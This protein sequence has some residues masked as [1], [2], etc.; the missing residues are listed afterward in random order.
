MNLHLNANLLRSGWALQTS[1]FAVRAGVSEKETVMNGKAPESRRC[2]GSESGF[3]LL[4]LMVSIAI[5]L[6]ITGATFSVMSSYQKSYGTTQLKADMYM[7]LRGVSE[8]MA[9]EIGQ[10]GLKITPT[11]PQAQFTG[12][13]VG[14]GFGTAP[15]TTSIG[16]AVGNQVMIDQGQPAQETVT[17][18]AVTTGVPGT[19]SATFGQNHTSGATVSIV[20]Q[21]VYA[22]GVLPFS[23]VASPVSTAGSTPSTLELFGD[24]NSNG[25][26]Q[27]VYYSCNPSAQQ[28]PVAGTLVR[29]ITRLPTPGGA[30]APQTLLNTLVVNPN[31]PVTGQP[32]PCFRLGTQT[33]AGTTFVSNVGVTLSVRTQEVDKVTGQYLVMTKSFMNL[34]PRNTLG[35]L[36]LSQ[37]QL[38]NYLLPTPAG[39]PL[40]CPVGYTCP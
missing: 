23:P 40:A 12:S 36:E 18:A 21:G 35:G 27:Y 8:L 17:I 37:Y 6:V 19:F 4:E 28:G 34:T 39:L 38:S 9:Q 5:L 33:V 15:V 10:A 26:L 20:G 13:V 31:D 30:N 2:A 14:G 7:N 29:S 3:S 32:I 1:A 11:Y 25:R 24:I 16:M 22:N